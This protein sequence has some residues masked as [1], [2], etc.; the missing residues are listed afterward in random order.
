[1][2]GVV[3]WRLWRDDK[4]VVHETETIAG[5]RGQAWFTKCDV[6]ATSRQ[7]WCLRDNEKGPVTCLACLALTCGQA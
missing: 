6:R 2:A 3:T 5:S 4:G 1:M 7:L